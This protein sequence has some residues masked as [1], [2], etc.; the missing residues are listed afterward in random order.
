MHKGTGP[1][2]YEYHTG[3]AS[4]QRFTYR[5]TGTFPDAKPYDVAFVGAP[6]PIRVHAV[7]GTG[8]VD[9]ITAGSSGEL[10]PSL[11]ISVSVDGVMRGRVATKHTTTNFLV[12]DD[13]KMFDDSG[14]LVPRA[15][16]YSYEGTVGYW[17]I[18]ARKTGHYW[19]ALR[20][21]ALVTWGDPTRP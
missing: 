14:R 21:Q 18:V 15:D 7:P 16:Q 20:M 1:G 2:D 10:G 3:E 9:G 17:R 11:L 12:N 4:N 8:M 5:L 19:T 13:T 6:G